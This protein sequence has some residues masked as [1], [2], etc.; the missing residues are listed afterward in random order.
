MI[1]RAAVILMPKEPFRAWITHDDETGIAD[2]FFEGMQEEPTVYLLPE[3]EDDEEQ[4]E[5]L[6]QCWPLLFE[7]ALSGWLVEPSMWPANRTLEMFREWF[8]VQVMPVVEDLVP[9][10]PIEHWE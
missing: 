2:S 7:S 8:D 3:W 4:G 6:A 5:V 10:E 1:N 9:D